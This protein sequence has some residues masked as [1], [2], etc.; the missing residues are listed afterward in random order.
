MKLSIL[1]NA[2]CHMYYIIHLHLKFGRDL[3]SDR[4]GTT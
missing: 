4:T 3:W 1:I 2:A